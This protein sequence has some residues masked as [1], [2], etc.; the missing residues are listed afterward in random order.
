M[1]HWRKP[2]RRGLV[3]LVVVVA[4]AIIL[5]LRQRPTP[6][7]TIIVERTDPEAVIQTRGSRILQADLLGENLRVVA[8]RQDT[9]RDGSLRLIDNVQVTIAD[10]NDRNGFV[11]TGNK[12]IVDAGKSEVQLQGNVEMESS[13]GLSA[14]TKSASYVDD[15]GIVRMPGSVSFER[16]N[17]NA[18][19]Q[20]AEYDRNHD[21]LHLLDGAHVNLR[22]ASTHTRILSRSATLAQTDEYMEFVDGVKIDTGDQQMT[23]ERAR[24]TTTDQGRLL[25]RVNLV[26]SATIM[27]INSEPGGLS[28]MSARSI[29]IDYSDDGETINAVTLTDQAELQTAGPSNTQGSWINGQSI[30]LAVEGNSSQLKEVIARKDVQLRI[31]SSGQM[32]DQAVSADLLTASSQGD[33]ELSEVQFE[34]NVLFQ[35]ISQESKDDNSTRTTRSDRLNA[36]FTESLSRL[37]S[38]HFQGNVRFKD[39]TLIGVADEA[40]YTPRNGKISLLTSSTS[41]RSPRVE[42]RRGSIQATSI[43]IELADGSIAADSE[44]KSVLGA[45]LAQSSD[46]P[47]R[48]GLLNDRESTYITADQLSYD[49]NTEVAVY[50][51]EARLWQGETEFTGDELILDETNGSL[52]ITGTANTRSIVNQ[53]GNETGLR[54]DSLIVGEAEL[55]IFDDQARTAT[56]E[57]SARLQGPQS[58][59]AADRIMLFLLEDSRTLERIEAKGSIELVMPGQ[60]VT[61]DSLVYHDTTGRYVMTG[62]PVHMTEN[63]AGIC[64]ETMGRTLTFFLTEDAVSVDG[65]SQ[66]RTETLRSDCPDQTP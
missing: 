62:S 19:G 18:A 22:N 14:R 47:H 66:V 29:E 45:I 46:Q 8:D 56:Y 50:S 38:A 24:I 13:N 7:D 36:V 10:R 55:F 39:K 63:Q 11:L 28:V 26:N 44:V 20:G 32:H 54:T 53:L 16:E 31:G 59:L 57:D 6:R 65:Q 48:P 49:R 23:A 17:M 3:L 35:E 27:A 37:S 40:K 43:H 61:G 15:G 51:F 30:V 60:T 58:D 34:G 52:S 42:D 2:L 41:G 5:E 64:R 33:A 1:N 25:E 21:V 12:A 4:A 9:Y